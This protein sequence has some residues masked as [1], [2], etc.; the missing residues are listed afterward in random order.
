MAI[1]IGLGTYEIWLGT[2]AFG[3]NELMNTLAHEGAHVMGLD[4]DEA[5]PIG[6][7]CAGDI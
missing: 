6:N 5:Y 1:V 2:P 7:A 4:D 3:G